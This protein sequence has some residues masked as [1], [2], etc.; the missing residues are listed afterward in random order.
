[1]IHNR[2]TGGFHVTF[3]RTNPSPRYRALL[4]QYQDLHVHGE[5]QLGL[6]PEKTF[7]GRSL[8][9]QAVRIGTLIRE[10]GA[11]TLLDYGCGKG[12]QYAPATID[13]GSGRKYDSIVDYWGIDSVHCFDPGYAPYS[14]RPAG[15]F[16]G[17]VCTDVLEHCP[18][19]DIP[20][21]LDEIFGYARRFVYANVA[22]YPAKKHLPNGENAHCTIKPVEWWAELLKTTAA[23]HPG[24]RW[25]VWVQSIVS[26]PQGSRMLE[27]KLR[28]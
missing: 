11:S 16:D 18:E 19:E 8:I 12:T 6:P 15:Q 23:R 26:S 22:C 4:S 2:P 3:T 7:D 9:P 10:T 1:L 5:K 28:G 21:I 20:W 27:E 17:V 24:V 25:E 13:D 14:E